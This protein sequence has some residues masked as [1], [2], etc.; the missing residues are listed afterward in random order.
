MGRKHWGGGGGGKEKLLIARNFS[1]SYTVFKRLLL[2]T[3][4]IQGFSGKGLT[5]YQMKNWQTC[6]IWKDLQT[7]GHKVG[8]TNNNFC[9]CKLGKT[10]YMLTLSQTSPVFSVQVCRTSLLKTLWEKEKL[11]IT[12][13]FS[14]SLSVVW[15]TFCL[16]YQIW[17]C[18]LQTFFVWKS[19]KFVIWERVKSSLQLAYIFHG[20]Y[21]YKKRA[22]KCLAQG[23]SYK[24]M[25][26]STMSWTPDQPYTIIPLSYVET[27]VLTHYQ[28]TNF[29]LFQTERVSRRQFQIWRKWKKV[30]QTGRK[31]CGKRRY[32][33]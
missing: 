18:C 1:F 2:Q 3:S 25:N 16:F 21:Q 22:P 29:R 7:T 5:L 23:H 13:N 24:K 9:H 4:K 32:C 33:S 11:L 30:I 26:E 20:F 6:P 28:T 19:L 8:G 14:F 15:R 27:P 17:N 31:H 10:H 12:R